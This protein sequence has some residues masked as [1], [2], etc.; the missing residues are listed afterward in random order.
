MKYIKLLVLL[1]APVLVLSSCKKS[2][3]APAV[4]YTMSFK[5]NGTLVNTDTQVANIP[6]GEKTITIDGFFNGQNSNMQFFISNNQVG[7]YDVVKDKLLL[8][9]YNTEGN[10]GT[11]YEA[12]SGTFT[13][14]TISATLVTGTFQFTASDTNG[15]AVT[16]TEGKFSVN[17][18]KADTSK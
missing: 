3:D 7:T 8:L 1:I 6:T 18:P 17:I 10:T 16:I 15:K 12:T 2:N 14:T 13:I 11:Y 9:Y 4:T 5:V